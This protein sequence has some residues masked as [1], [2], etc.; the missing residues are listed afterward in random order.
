MFKN[1]ILF[2]IIISVSIFQDTY[3]D[4]LNKKLS[5]SIIVTKHQIEQDYENWKAYNQAL[6]TKFIEFRRYKKTATLNQLDR[7]LKQY[8]QDAHEKTF[9]TESQ[10]KKLNLYKNIYYRTILLRDYI[11]K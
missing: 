7:I 4:D 2:I 3:A 9:L 6:E 10:R 11:L 5:K 1:F 8:I